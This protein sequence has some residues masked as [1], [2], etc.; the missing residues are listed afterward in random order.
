MDSKPRTPFSAVRKRLSAR[1]ASQLSEKQRL[2][3]AGEL[4]G[5]DAV[6]EWSS[7]KGLAGLKGRVVDESLGTFV[8]STPAGEKRVSKKSCAFFFPGAGASIEGRALLFRPEER[9][10]RMLER[11]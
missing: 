3:L 1:R 2:F 11:K 6:V 4:I 7:D 8:L 5:E 10:K 9:T